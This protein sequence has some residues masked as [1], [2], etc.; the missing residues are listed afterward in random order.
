MKQFSSWKISLIQINL[1]CLQLKI[2]PIQGRIS[3][4]E[5]ED[6]HAKF[7]FSSSLALA[8]EL[9][10][11]D[12]HQILYLVRKCKYK[13]GIKGYLAIMLNYS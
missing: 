4:W 9:Q 11:T 12:P 13:S 8:V 2:Q 3:L 7:V 1:S 6:H 5:E 10:G